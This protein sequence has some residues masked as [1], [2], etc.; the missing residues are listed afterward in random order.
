MAIVIC[1]HG[2]TALNATLVVQPA[3]TL[4][5]ARGIDQ[6]E[7]LSTRLAKRRVA[8][9][10][11]SD[12]RRARMTAEPLERA[13]A[14]RA[15]L[16]DLLQERNFGDLR[17]TPYAQLDADI[18]APGYVPPNGESWEAFHDRVA[19]AWTHCLAA[20]RGIDGDLVVI[21][22]GLFCR[23]LVARHL[24]LPA[25]VAVPGRWENTAV[26]VVAEE[27]PH[28]VMLLACT[29]HLEPALASDRAAR[30]HV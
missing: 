14:L 5:D 13:T 10:L 26:T 6:A 7:R 3:D 11:S 2:Q 9:I 4:L 22:H 15:E 19:R 8:R 21:T 23:V 24:E 20:A 16:S 25:G 1:R 12:L 18:Y 27:P 30:G 29:E 28:R 17:G